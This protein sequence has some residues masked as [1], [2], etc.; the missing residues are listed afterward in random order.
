VA[1]VHNKVLRPK[2]LRGSLAGFVLSKLI[3]QEVEV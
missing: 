1:V 2:E 3:N